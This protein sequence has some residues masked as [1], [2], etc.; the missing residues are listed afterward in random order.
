MA[1]RQET[2][3][4]G[5]PAPRLYLVTEAAMFSDLAPALT[6]ALAAT[7]VAAVLLTLGD[8]D[9]RAKINW[10]KALAPAIQD[11]GAALLL[12]EHPDLVARAGA[13]GAH[14]HGIEALREALGGL[15]PDRIAGV[16]RLATRHEAMLAAEAGADY[17]MFG[18][19][20]GAQERP[21]LD[22]I[23]DRIAW[24]S[25][26]FQVPC[27]GYAATLEEVGPLAGAGADFIALAASLWMGALGA[28][29]VREA[30]RRLTMK[31][32]V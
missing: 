10:I 2:N 26:L 6:S 30:H 8:A 7:D 17:V 25:E 32:A 21:G 18:E 22:A 9:E 28:S 14:L 16:G 13:D 15:K 23:R 19:P 12:D 29:N 5:R 27:V 31:E 4:R 20:T 1:T 24:W 11:R 3:G